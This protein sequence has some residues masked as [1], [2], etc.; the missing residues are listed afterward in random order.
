MEHFDLHRQNAAVILDNASYAAARSKRPIIADYLRAMAADLRRPIGEMEESAL[1]HR[2]ALSAKPE[3]V[4]E[5]ER[6]SL[7]EPVWRSEALA[8]RIEVARLRLEVA[9]LG[10]ELARTNEEPLREARAAGGAAQ[11]EVEGRIGRFT[12][13]DL[14]TG[15]IT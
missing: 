13:I 6:L 3:H 9:K 2:E 12:S 5:Y 10:M 14:A 11:R 8:S 4:S 15:A 7:A 1:R